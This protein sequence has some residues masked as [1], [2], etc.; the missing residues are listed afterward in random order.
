MV[1]VITYLSNA[2]NLI[3]EIATVF[4][5]VAHLSYCPFDCI[6]YA[7]LLSPHV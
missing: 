4:C 6:T 2:V 7:F 5:I 3:Q 1:L